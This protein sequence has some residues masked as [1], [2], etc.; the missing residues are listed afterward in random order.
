MSLLFY[1]DNNIKNNFEIFIK[2]DYLVNKLFAE[3]EINKNSNLYYYTNFRILEKLCETL[4]PINEYLLGILY[5]T[6]SR[7]ND[8]KGVVGLLKSLE[9]YFTLQTINEL[10]TIEILNDEEL[11]FIFQVIKNPNKYFSFL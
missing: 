3:F 1:S 10:K 9:I 6:P 5:K 11:E 7:F 8:G 2:I 4:K